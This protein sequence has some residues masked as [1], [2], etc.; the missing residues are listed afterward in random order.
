MASL[1]LAMANATQ[2]MLLVIA[3]QDGKGQAAKHQTALASRTATIVVSATMHSQRLHAKNAM[4]VGWVQLVLIHVSTVNKSLWTLEYVNA[5]KVGLARDVILNAPA[6]GNEKVMARVRAIT[7]KVSGAPSAKSLDALAKTGKIALA[8]ANATV[9]LP[10]AHAIQVGQILAVMLLIVLE[11]QTATI[12]ERASQTP[13]QMDQPALTASHRRLS[14]VNLFRAG[15]AMRAISRVPTVRKAQR[16]LESVSAMPGTLAMAATWSARVT[17][18]SRMV[19]VNADRKILATRGLA[20][21]A[22][23]RLVQDQ[24]VHATEMASATLPK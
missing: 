15:W 20:M 7:R 4:L 2:Q 9:L 23:P 12:E 13:L 6:T 17:G 5:T 1:A 10:S 11:I 8:T 18:R 14:T 21:C 19:N 3:R 22:R 16:T 24:T